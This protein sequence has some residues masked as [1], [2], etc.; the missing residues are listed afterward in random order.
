MGRSIRVP[1]PRLLTHTQRA[2][3]GSFSPSTR[4][5]IPVSRRRPPC[6]SLLPSTWRYAETSHS[7]LL[8]LLTLNP[9]LHIA[10]VEFNLVADALLSRGNGI[11]HLAGRLIAARDFSALLRQALRTIDVYD[12]SRRRK[13]PPLFLMR[14]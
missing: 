3:S 6:H 1:V 5:S 7:R 11:E 12:R 9:L 14:A 2:S 10:T 8:E 4:V 13:H